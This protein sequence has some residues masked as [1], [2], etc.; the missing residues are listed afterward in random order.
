MVEYLNTS[1]L[2]TETDYK[3]RNSS[4]NN[5]DPESNND[6]STDLEKDGSIVVGIRSGITRRIFVRVSF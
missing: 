5:G 2:L 1:E 4:D 6:T 3:Y